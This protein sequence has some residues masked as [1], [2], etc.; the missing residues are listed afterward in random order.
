MKKAIIFVV[1]I[2]VA[3][4]AFA[5]PRNHKCP[6]CSGTMMWT[7]ETATEWGKLTYQMKCPVGH[8]SWEVDDFNNSSSRNINKNGCQYDGS[9][10]MWTGKTKT[11]WGKLLKEYKC[12][13][14]HVE[15][16]PQ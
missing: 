14:G 7:G 11:E 4:F 5:V 12:P 10:M 8:I 13:A 3:V 6:I 1:F 15:W 9:T 16:R 2:L